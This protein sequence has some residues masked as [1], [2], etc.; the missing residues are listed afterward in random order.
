MQRKNLTLSILNFLYDCFTK[1]I[2]SVENAIER[3]SSGFEFRIIK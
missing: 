3:E 2:L 1:E